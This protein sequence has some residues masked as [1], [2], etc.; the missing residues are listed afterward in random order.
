MWALSGLADSEEEGM[1]W[2]LRRQRAEPGPANHEAHRWLLP[3]GSPVS[4]QT[5][6]Y[7]KAQLNDLCLAT[8]T[9]SSCHRRSLVQL[10]QCPP[11]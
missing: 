9:S 1:Q 7:K 5:R 11:G 4:R 6:P 10:H 3:E 2:L 8:R